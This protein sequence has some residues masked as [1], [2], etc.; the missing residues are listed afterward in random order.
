MATKTTERFAV[1]TAGLREL[2]AGR[3]PWTL[4][5]ELVQNAWDEFP[6][7]TE[8]A[9]TIE[10]GETRGTLDVTVEDNGAGFRN[11]ADAWTLMGPTAKRLEPTKRGRFNLGEKEIIAVSREARIETVGTTIIFPKSGGREVKRNRRDGG[12]IIQATMPW[13]WSDLDDLVD[14][15]RRFRPTGCELTVNG[16]PVEQREPLA[17]FEAALETIIQDAPGEPLRK[18]RRR[19]RVDVLPRREERGWLYELGI[20]VQVIE[21]PFDV[22]VQQK[23]PMPP[24]RDTVSAA[25][26]QDICAEVLNATHDQLDGEQASEAWVGVALEDSRVDEAAVQGVVKARHGDKV[27]IWSSNPEANVRAIEDGYEVVHP[28]SMSPAERRHVKELGGV[29]STN[30]LFGEQPKPEREP[31]P[32]EFAEMIVQISRQLAAQLTGRAAQEAAAVEQQALKLRA[33]IAAEPRKEG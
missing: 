26:L 3:E 14:A 9:V 30:D 10:R 6:A 2:H 22:D 7:A 5:K 15:L 28:R 12:T 32:D 20:P 27:A 17:V 23:I 21:L 25:Y 13:R 16:E 29:Q 8:C 18:S 19:V 11:P 4:L 1:S 24:N 31:T 33:A